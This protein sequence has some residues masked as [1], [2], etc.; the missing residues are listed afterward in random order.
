MADSSYLI[1][2]YSVEVTEFSANSKSL[3]VAERS[4]EGQR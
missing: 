4:T 3:A 2:S 1:M